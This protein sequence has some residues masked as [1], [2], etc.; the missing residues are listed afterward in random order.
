VVLGIMCDIEKETGCSTEVTVRSLMD[1]WGWDREP[2]E[3]FA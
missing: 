3:S 1:E 2:L